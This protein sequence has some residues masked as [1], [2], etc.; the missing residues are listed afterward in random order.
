MLFQNVYSQNDAFSELVLINNKSNK[1]LIISEGN[2][3]KIITKDDLT[4]VEPFY[5]KNDS[6]LIVD[7][8]EFYLNEIMDIKY[9]EADKKIPG[10]LFFS[11]G[12]LSIVT[13]AT[14]AANNEPEPGVLG[15]GASLGMA[16]LGGALIISGGI[17]S[18]IGTG[19]LIF[20]RNH[21][22]AQGWSYSI[23]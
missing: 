22:K 13:G 21:K 17:L 3:V 1:E 2:E 19:V 18:G 8:K 4:F 12:G 6:T 10:I 5:I 20:N 14:I 11:L 23:Q 15:L 16:S 7:D 9:L